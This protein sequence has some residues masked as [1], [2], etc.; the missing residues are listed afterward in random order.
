MHHQ[1]RATR[2]APLSSRQDCLR[3]GV[4]E[5]RPSTL[6]R[7]GPISGRSPR[8]SRPSGLW[9][10]PS[11]VSWGQPG[12]TRGSGRRGGIPGQRGL[13]DPPPAGPVRPGRC[14]LGS[15][16]PSPR[17]GI[18]SRGARVTDPSSIRARSDCGR[19]SR[20]GPSEKPHS[21]RH[22][23]AGTNGSWV[24]RR[25]R[26]CAAL[27]V[28][29]VTQQNLPNTCGRFHCWTRKGQRP[30]VSASRSGRADRM[31]GELAESLRSV[32]AKRCGRCARSKLLPCPCSHRQ[33]R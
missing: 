9:G 10:R 23:R 28:P 33:A 19:S 26:I 20:L 32:A 24:G 29:A 7:R 14:D 21:H 27:P 12:P 1:R 13:G 11:R 25:P 3:G 18:G 5:P 22:V 8:S 15:R 2:S 30:S 16:A 4:S 17:C 6:R 31:I